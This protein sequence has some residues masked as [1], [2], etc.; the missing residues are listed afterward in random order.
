ML[1]RNPSGSCDFSH[2]VIKIDKLLA[3][4]LQRWNLKIFYFSVVTGG[5]DGIGKA[6]LIELARRGL[7]K[8]VVIG[9]NQNK[10]DNVKSY[11]G[12]F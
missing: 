2:V 5:T 10:L 9:R 8:F 4:F 7:R 1:S 12:I 11:L 3:S 6:Y